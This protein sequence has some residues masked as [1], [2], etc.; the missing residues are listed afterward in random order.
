MQGEDGVRVAGKGGIR[1]FFVYKKLPDAAFPRNT[2]TILPLHVIPPEEALPGKPLRMTS[3]LHG[4]TRT[5]RI[6]PS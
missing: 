2:D 6:N 4:D 1:K 3:L 5:V